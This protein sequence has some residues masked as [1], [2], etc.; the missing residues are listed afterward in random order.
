MRSFRKTILL[1]GLGL[2]FIFMVFLWFFS[3]KESIAFKAGI[4]FLGF[5]ILLLH[6][7]IVRRLSR[8][9]QQIMDAILPYQEGRET[10]LPR[11]VLDPTW[12]TSEF[13]KLAVTLNS[14]TFKIQKQIEAIMRQSKETEGILE[15]LNEGVIA[16]DVSAKVTF[17][18]QVACK[19]F[20]LHRTSIIGQSLHVHSDDFFQ[21]CH[22]L[23]LQ[24][25]QTSERTVQTWKMQ[26]RHLDLISAPLIHQS[27][28][29]LVLQDKTADYKVLEVGKNFIANASHELRTPITILRG[30]AEML[31]DVSL[32]SPQALSDISSKMVRTCGRLDKLIKGLLTLADIENRREDRFFSCDLVSLLENCRHL[33]LTAH[34][35]ARVHISSKM[36]HL[37]ISA[38]GDLLDLA[39][40]NLLENAVKYS[41]DPIEIDVSMQKIGSSVQIRIQD[42]GMGIP[43]ADLPHIF[44]R[45]YT[46]DKARSRKSGGVGLGLSIVKTIIDKHKG[47]V[48]AE[49]NTKGTVFTI[50]LPV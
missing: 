49:S 18:N 21:K 34:P 13:G 8:P 5:F 33:L 26:Q 28:A 17:I 42:K 36:E 4:F 45:F 39:I 47:T 46:V 29:I 2:F 7:E 24:A 16:F 1:T 37:F 25:L 44:E 48:T 12:Q 30:F 20:G 40:G 32:L 31:Q 23:V 41:V 11:I 6:W 3:E 27:G 9:M 38:D 35:K 19:L 43:K 15:S 50:A 14:L 22:E 10:P